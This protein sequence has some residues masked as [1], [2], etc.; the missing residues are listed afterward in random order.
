MAEMTYTGTLEVRT[1]PCCS[2]TY[3]LTKQFTDERRNNGGSWF[4][5]YCGSKRSFVQS[6][7]DKQRQRAE[8]AEAQAARNAEYARTQL[9]RAEREARRAAAARGQVT[10]IKRR[11]AKGCCPSCHTTFPDLAEH[12]AAEHPE[13][14]AQPAD[15]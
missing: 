1:C 15:G 8:Q 6:E 11:A 14:A 5:P 12:M 7:L 3:A 10:K 9:Q 2:G 13:F 4:C